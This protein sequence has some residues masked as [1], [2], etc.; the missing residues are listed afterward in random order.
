VTHRWGLATPCVAI[1]VAVCLAGQPAWGHSFPPVRTIVVQAERCELAVLVGY[2]PASGEATDTLLRRIAGQPRFSMLAAA[3][4]LLA[5]EA[6][7]P[8][9]FTVDGTPLVP[10]KVRAKI[11]T[12]PGGARP[13]VIVLVTYAI[14]AAGSLH[15]SS[16]DA[17]S[18]RIS[19]VD[20]D[21]GRVDLEQ[22]PAQGRWFT[23]VASFLLRLAAPPGDSRCATPSSLP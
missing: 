5:K 14:P 18:T 4:Q 15:V 23:G 7:A 22:L 11:G 19:W 12:D 21:S 3:K 8:L 17:R 20:R 9:S 2:R 10:T 6:L 1:A 16:R 13:M